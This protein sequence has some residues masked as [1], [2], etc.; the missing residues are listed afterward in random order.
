MR[1]DVW[2]G[3]QQSAIAFVPQ[4]I[5]GSTA[6]GFVGLTIKNL[7][8]GNLCGESGFKGL[9]TQNVQKICE[10]FLK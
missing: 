5:M 2:R 1:G 4:G 3:T 9:K 7:L 6:Y 8:K 10:I